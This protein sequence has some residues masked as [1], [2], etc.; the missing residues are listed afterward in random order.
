VMGKNQKIVTTVLWGFLVLTMLA[1]VGTGLWAQRRD[2]V[3]EMPRLY[4]TPAFTL[5]DQTGKTVLSRDLR[6]APWV[7]AFVFTN[8][9]A[10]CPM[11]AQKF[12]ALQDQTSGTDLKLVSFTVDPERDTP[13]V[14]QAYARR[15]GADTSRWRFLTGAKQDVFAAAAGMKISAIP[16]TKDAPIIHGDHFLLVDAGGWVRGVYRS[17]D[18][19][20][21]QRI[22]ADAAALA[23]RG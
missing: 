12:Q 16:A 11:M 8:C 19:D 21:I 10:D 6:G 2:D 4:E 3:E 18:A 1:V 13:E 5:T 20:M 17:R 15:L 22:V 23:G 7:A 14:L 9:A